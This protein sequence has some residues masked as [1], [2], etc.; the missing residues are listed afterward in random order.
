MQ[1][2]KQVPFRLSD[3]DR[4]RIAAIRDHFGLPSE[5]AAVRYA[6]QRQ[7]EAIPRTIEQATVPKRRV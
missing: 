1:P 3:A 4:E 2:K 6:V 7:W 5:A